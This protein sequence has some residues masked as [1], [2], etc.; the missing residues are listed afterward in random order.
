MEY[1]E[2]GKLELYNL[3]DDLGET[4]NLATEKPEIA[5]QMH[6][7]MA[8]W[9]KD[10]NAPMPVKNEPGAAPAAVKKGKGKGKKKA[11]Q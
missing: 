11:N 7:R 3:R 1:L 2:D 9:R 10:V 4:K 5:G 6:A 8:A